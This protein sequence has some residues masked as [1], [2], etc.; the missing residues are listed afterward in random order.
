[1]RS[2]HDD[3]ANLKDGRKTLGFPKAK[4]VIRIGLSGGKVIIAE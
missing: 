1:M 2:R 3:Q 4:A